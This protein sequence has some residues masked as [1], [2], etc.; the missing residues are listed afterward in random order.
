MARGWTDQRAGSARRRERVAASQPLAIIV[1]SVSA[2]GAWTAHDARTSCQRGQRRLIGSE[3]R[4]RTKV[5]W[6][7]F[8]IPR[9]S[10]AGL[11]YAPYKTRRLLSLDRD[12][13]T[14]QIIT[15]LNRA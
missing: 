4:K 11:V 14:I 13:T 8:L 10:G 5:E 1:V 7:R 2:S 9:E 12:N 6:A 3:E 15:V